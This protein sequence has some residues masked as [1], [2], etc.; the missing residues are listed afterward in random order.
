MNAIL[1][2]LALPCL[3]AAGLIALPAQAET[4]TCESRSG[5][6]VSCPIS[7][8]GR[9]TLSRQLSS[10]GCWENDTWGH[11]RNRVW[12]T[13]G[14]RA[15]FDVGS[16]SR[17]DN[18]DAAVGAAVAIGL[19]GAAILASKHDRDK[20]RDRDREDDRYDGGRP[21]QTFD[22]GSSDNR[23]TYCDAGRVRGHVEV[24][25]Q[26]S[27]SACRYGDSWGMEGNRVW[28]DRGCRATFAVY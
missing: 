4:V 1:R 13:N 6:Y 14:C 20:D 12:V 18:K 27:K 22:C 25:R 3:A 8:G 19:I 5:S 9:V 2:A 26:Q 7:N 16:T 11:D 28:V 10:Q 21:R 15:E 24:Y 17:S 23:F